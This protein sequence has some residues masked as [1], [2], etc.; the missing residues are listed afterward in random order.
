MKRFY[1]QVEIDLDD[2]WELADL[3]SELYSTQVR[4]ALNEEDG[5]EGL[6]TRVSV[7]PF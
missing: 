6:V 1:V 5:F 7:R 3:S 4:L 2:E